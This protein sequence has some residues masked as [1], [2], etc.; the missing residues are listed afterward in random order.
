MLIRRAKSSSQPSWSP[1]LLLRIFTSDPAAKRS[2]RSA[3]FLPLWQNEQ[4]MHPKNVFPA[5]LRLS[6]QGRKLT[7][8]HILY[9]YIPTMIY[10]YIYIFTKTIYIYKPY[11]YITYIYIYIHVLYIYICIYNPPFKGEVVGVKTEIFQKGG[12]AL[13]KPRNISAKRIWFLM[14]SPG[15]K[16]GI[17]RDPPH[18]VWKPKNMWGVGIFHAVRWNISDKFLVLPPPKYSRVKGGGIIYIYNIYIYIMYIYIYMT[19]IYITY[20]SI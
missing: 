10:I 6:W 13:P 14:V 5:I 18:S 8:F 15:L 3:T 2:S 19:Y 9:I 20:I 4:K 1:W 12:V 16:C 7:Q 11:I 17:R